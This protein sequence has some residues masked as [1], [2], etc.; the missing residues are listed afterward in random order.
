VGKF[1]K[2]I[3][4]WPLGHGVGNL[5]ADKYF[6]TGRYILHPKVNL[7]LEATHKVPHSLHWKMER[8]L[9]E[10]SGKHTVDSLGT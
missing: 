7:H 6:A 4:F 2:L 10:Q 8:G 9:R 3:I 1:I 5:K